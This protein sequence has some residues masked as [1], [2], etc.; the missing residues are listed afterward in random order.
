MLRTVRSN[1][2]SRPTRVAAIHTPVRSISLAT[3]GRVSIP[4]ATSVLRPSVYLPKSLVNSFATAKGRGRPK[5][6]KGGKTKA[7]SG[8]VAKSKKAKKPR[9][10][11]EKQ[12]AKQE[13]SKRRELVKQLKITA[14]TPPEKLPQNPRGVGVQM[15]YPEVDK[16]QPTVQR[17]REVMELV[18]SMSPE[19]REVRFP[20]I[21]VRLP[22]LTMYPEGEGYSRIK[23]SS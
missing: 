16:S 12:K 20:P 6:T 4:L 18:N 19:E 23:Q 17:L 22:R 5:G 14:L 13:A 21:L 1:V 10:L 9:E 8:A 2:F 11:T 7:K 15:K 3:T